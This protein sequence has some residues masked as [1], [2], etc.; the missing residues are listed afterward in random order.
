M[1]D[2]LL[3]L[4]ITLFWLVNG[5]HAAAL[6]VF[7]AAVTFLG[8][9][10]VAAPLMVA[11]VSLRP[12]P[13]RLNRI[14]IMAAVAISV[15]GLVNSATIKPIVRR[16]RPLRY[17]ASHPERV[18]AG[19][20]G[21]PMKVHVIGKPLRYRSFPSGH[22]NT[23]FAAGSVLIVL[24]GGWAWSALVPAALVGYS[25]IYLGVHF[26]L[27]VLVGATLGGGIAWAVMARSRRWWREDTKGEAG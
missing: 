21:R 1:I 18:P 4:D 24:Y 7:F 19:E 8:T 22:T 11:I 27:D 13:G 2:D 20:E 15:S 14:I 16:P 12:P 6:D 3:G 9:G 10:W 23:A 25:R 26:P 5:S 17:F